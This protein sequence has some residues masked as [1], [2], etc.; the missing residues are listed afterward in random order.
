[1]RLLLIEDDL[2]IGE[3]VRKGLRMQ[4]FTVDWVRDDN[5]AQLALRH[6][7]YHLIL[8]DLGLP[9]R[10]GLDILKRLRADGSELPV[11][12]VTARDAVPDRITG[13]NMGADD[14]LIKP[15]DL[16]ELTARIWALLR[17]SAGRA[18]AT[19]TA[20]PLHLN[21]VTHQVTYVG[22]RIPLSAR[23]FSVLHA[24][25][26][27]PGAVLSREQLEDR[28]YG[29]GDEVASNAVEVHIH[30]LRKKLGQ[31]VI[32]SIRGV[33]YRIVSDHDI[34]S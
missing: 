24:L 20:G 34:D 21:P 6:T 28:L 25:M 31:R 23:E 9:G 2:M 4:G 16:D 15:F 29:W 12:I 27:I 32:K 5:A 33:G 3:S 19:I 26:E 13:L 14:Y 1:M 18:D 10:D 30:N 8:L 7:A 22:K 17:R 11:L